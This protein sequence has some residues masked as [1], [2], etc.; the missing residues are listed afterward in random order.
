MV[1]AEHSKCSGLRPVWVR[2]PPRALSVYTSF[3]D[4]PMLGMTDRPAD[5]AIRRIETVLASDIDEI[6]AE[7]A[8]WFRNLRR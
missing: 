3:R 4:R 7:F 5:D 8:A 2:V 1:D 6:D